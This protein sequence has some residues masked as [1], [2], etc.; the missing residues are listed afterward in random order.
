MKQITLQCLCKIQIYYSDISGS[1]WQ[2]KRNEV[3]ANNGDL[4]IDNG[5]FNSQSFKYKTALVGK[6]ADVNNG[7]SFVKN[8]L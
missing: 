3:P 8:T 2:F 6:T 1:S 7:N 5:T 4:N